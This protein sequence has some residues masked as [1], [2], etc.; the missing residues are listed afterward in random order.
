M[1]TIGRFRNEKICEKQILYFI[2]NKLR[3]MLAL[4]DL[5]IYRIRFS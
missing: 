2:E 3:A 1:H 4:K 5:S